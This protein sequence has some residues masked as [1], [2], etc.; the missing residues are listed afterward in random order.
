[1]VAEREFLVDFS[2]CFHTD[3][4]SF[5]LDGNGICIDGGRLDVLVDRMCLGS[6]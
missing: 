5:G 1:M 4:D 2:S 3:S 6:R